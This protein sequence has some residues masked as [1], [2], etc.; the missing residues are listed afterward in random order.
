MRGA[1]GR[2]PWRGSPPSGTS[3][4]SGGSALRLRLNVAVDDPGPEAAPEPRR[5]ATARAVDWSRVRAQRASA[6]SLDARESHRSVDVGFRLADRDKRVAAGVLAGGV[7]YRLFFWLLSVS[8]LATGAFGI[9]RGDRVD[10]VLHDLGLGPATSDIVKQLMRGS[11]DA[12]WLVS[13]VGAW[14]VLWTGYLG[15]KALVLVHAAVWGV[16][17]PPARRHW[18]MSLAFTGTTLGILVAMSLAARVHTEGLAVGVLADV[19]AAAVPFTA[20]LVVSGWLPRRGEGW[21]DLLPGAVL[22][23]IGVETFYLVAT[24]FLAPKLANATQLYGLLGISATI[25]FWLFILGRLIIG[26]ATLNL[27]LYENRIA[28]RPSVSE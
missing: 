4:K 2:M 11:D 20:W 5:G 1:P 23:A 21:R 24:W 22:M 13:A 27:S 18:A 6:W 25:L 15:A 8:V 19:L 16:P 26:A 7:A 12:R 28:T 14:L 9:A 3:P 10:E 17:A